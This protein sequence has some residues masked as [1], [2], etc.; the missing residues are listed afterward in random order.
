MDL[1]LSE[2]YGEGD[3]RLIKRIFQKLRAL[4]SSIR[5]KFIAVFLVS[6]AI[7]VGAYFLVHYVSYDYI[8][9]VYSSEENKKEREIEYIKDLQEFA[10]KNQISI[11]NAAKLSEW[12]MKNKY[13]YLLIYK[14][15][16]L[17]YT[18]DDFP[19]LPEE[20]PQEKP[21]QETP[22]KNPEETPGENPEES[23]EE[24]PEE[25]P[26]ENP[27]ESPEENPE[28]NPGEN[29]EESPEENPD[30][31]PG[32]N[33]EESPEEN[34]G[35]NPEEAPGENTEENPEQVP[36][37]TPEE[38]PGETPEQAPNDNPN[39]E[40]QGSESEDDKGN[41]TSGENSEK[42]DSGSATDK[43]NP[44]EEHKGPGGVTIDYPT[45]EELFE[46]AKK[47][48]LH[49][50]KL[51]DGTLLARLSEFTEYVYYDVF[52]IVSL[53]IAVLIVLIIL[54]LYFH[55]VTTRIIRL[56]NEVNK[57]ADGDVNHVIKF[58][59]DDEIA[60]LSL[61]VDNM[62]ESMIENFRK[63]KEA[64]DANNSLITS[65]SHDIRTPLTVL[66][67]YIDV[68]QSRTENDT[69]MQG[70]LKAAES[71]ALRLKKLSDDMFGYFLVFGGK[72]LEIKMES[73]DA[74]TL[75]EQMLFEHVTLMRESGYTV[76]LEGP[77]YDELEGFEIRTDAQKLIRIFDNVF[78][79]IYKYADKVSTVSISAKRTKDEI[80]ISFS[81]RISKNG[82][83][84]ESNGIG[85][86]TCKK[87]GEYINASFECVSD[88]ETFTAI[89][90]LKLVKNKRI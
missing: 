39:E 35:E 77:Y 29:P 58:K 44:D 12:A 23:P 25:N 53:I 74:H 21:P 37:E 47:N 36:G 82:S 19:T 88:V 52:N 5:V 65:M 72:E 59:G 9:R 3:T 61:N 71:T 22:D 10:N 87:L 8:D 84:A 70:Y 1:S 2:P 41:N 45:R 67:G 18:S 38:N 85:L 28:E 7:G 62:R 64:I 30:E 17:L 49:P 51:S 11:D 68:M 55:L 27:E 48:D 76:E 13:V 90:K 42:P 24:N 15:T 31:N 75:I 26:G 79:N 66:L 16:E 6:V 40:N 86:K 69:E 33:P 83:M 80:E 46:Y 78:S 14:D 20:K 73:Y 50:I 54:T 4:F 34:P 89:L 57:V 56:G 43:E 81:N 60:K 32:E 63:E